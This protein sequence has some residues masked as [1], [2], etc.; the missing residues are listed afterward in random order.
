MMLILAHLKI[1]TETQNNIL[2]CNSNTSE[3]LKAE[4]DLECTM[5]SILP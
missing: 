3:G 1:D 4:R 5:I 2:S